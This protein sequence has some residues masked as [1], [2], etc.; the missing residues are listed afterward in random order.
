LI[1]IHAGGLLEDGSTESATENQTALERKF[2][3][4]GE[5]VV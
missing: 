5:K 3:G 1:E 2:R 4:K